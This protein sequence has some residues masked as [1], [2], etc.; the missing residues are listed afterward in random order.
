M[1]EQLK[2]ALQ[3]T[4]RRLSAAE[5]SQILQLASEL[6]LQLDPEEAARLV[7]GFETA[8]PPAPEDRAPLTWYER[9][10]LWLRRLMADWVS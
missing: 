4:G 8:E 3:L 2:A 7:K 9:L 6:G 10:R 5:R 1:R